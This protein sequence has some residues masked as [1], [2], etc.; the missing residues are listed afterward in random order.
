MVFNREGEVDKVEVNKVNE[1]DEDD[2]IVEVDDAKEIDAT[3]E[4]DEVNG[5]KWRGRPGR[6]VLQG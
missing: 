5:V 2:K 1:V 6:S 4:A 3:N